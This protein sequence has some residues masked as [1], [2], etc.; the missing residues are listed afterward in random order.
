MPGGATGNIAIVPC[1]LINTST[2][3]TILATA[4]ISVLASKH[5]HLVISRKFHMLLYFFAEHETFYRISIKTLPCR[6]SNTFAT[7]IAVVR[8]SSVIV[9]T[10][11]HNYLVISLIFYI[12]S[13]F[14]TQQE[15]FYLIFVKTVPCRLSNTIATTITI[16][17]TSTIIVFASRHHHLFMSLNFHI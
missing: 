8:P 3:I 4:T 9:L 10:S 2:T 5:N 16:V 1:W 6:L 15:I 7:A 12:L 13:Y 17:L 11:K 14:L